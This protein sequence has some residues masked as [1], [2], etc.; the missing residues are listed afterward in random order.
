MKK[1]SLKRTLV[2]T[3]LLVLSVGVWLFMYSNATDSSTL[4]IPTDKFTAI[5]NIQQVYFTPRTPSDDT[6]PSTAKV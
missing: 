6:L 3:S 1:H 2:L 4:T 5:Q